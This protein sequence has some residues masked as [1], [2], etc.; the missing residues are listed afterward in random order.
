MKN[1]KTLL[2]TLVA[3]VAISVVEVKA[4]DG[5]FQIA[6]NDVGSKAS[7]VLDPYEKIPYVEGETS[8]GVQVVDSIPSEILQFEVPLYVTMAVIDT[9]ESVL[10]PS[11]YGITNLSGMDTDI[12]VIWVEA[13]A[14][15]TKDY[16]DF[17]G[18]EDDIN[19]DNQMALN[20]GGMPIEL[21]DGETVKLDLIDSVF[22]NKDE[23]K[24]IPIKVDEKRVM[25]LEGRVK[26][27]VRTN[28]PA[29]AQFS[30][31]YTVSQLDESGDP[32]GVY[33]E[34]PIVEID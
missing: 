26:S 7:E 11:D 27:A 18:T 29:V 30:L 19:D 32:V 1:K 31:K 14:R 24:F 5:L 22:Y 15:S 10:T 8:L 17:V 2:L 34:G 3:L 13:T 25:N 23:K 6:S 28:K 9:K 21:V 4:H 16:W 20:V 12:A 33:Y